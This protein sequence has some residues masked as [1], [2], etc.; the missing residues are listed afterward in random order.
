MTH[1]MSEQA[2]EDL[3]K[4]PVLMVVAVVL[5]IIVIGCVVLLYELRPRARTGA[6]PS[7]P[8]ASGAT[9]TGSSMA[10]PIGNSTRADRLPSVIPLS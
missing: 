5:A 9:V 6:G 4:P 3:G 1:T 10:P 7:V 2:P 8:A